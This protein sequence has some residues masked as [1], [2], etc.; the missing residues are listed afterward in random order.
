MPTIV[1]T[2]GPP[3]P[4]PAG[5]SAVPRFATTLPSESHGRS[6]AAVTLPGGPAAV[7]ESLGGEVLGPD[8]VQELPELLDLGLLLVLVEEDAG[9]LEDGLVGEDRDRLGGAG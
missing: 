6:Y 7:N 9:L 5:L 8:L 1:H 3:K 2:W 4:S